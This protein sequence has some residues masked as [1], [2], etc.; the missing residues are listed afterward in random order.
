MQD[1]NITALRA[2][3]SL[4]RTGRVS[5]TAEEL[6]LTQPAVSR[7]IAALEAAS[8]VALLHRGARPLA[9]TEEGQTAAAYARDITGALGA[10]AQQMESFRTHRSGS[11][12]AGSFG[13]SASTRILPPLL[14]DFAARYPGIQVEVS[15]S[16]DSRA[17]DD[18]RAGLTDLSVLADPGDAFETVPI[19][20][21]KL[22]ALVPSGSPGSGLLTPADLAQGPFIM[23][24]GGSEPFILDWFRAA[25]VMPQAVH[26]V[27]QTH[28]ILAMV[29]NGLGRAVVAG[30]SLPEK[31]PG[32]QQLQLADA[33]ERR[34]VLARKH[35]PPRSHAAAALWDFAERRFSGA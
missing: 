28:S 25:G 3:Q 24:Q 18:L 13:A 7:A 27:L 11:V 6:G 16:D 12:R 23:T 9:L 1:L 5:A 26:R 19:A 29:A 2:L 14:K 10:F 21:D 31:T 34:I 30:L 35:Q 32:V 33:P 20:T 4:E 15:E 17:L 8:G 22:I